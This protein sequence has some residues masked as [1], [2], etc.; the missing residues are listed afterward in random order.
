[1]EGFNRLIEAG[2]VDSDRLA[3]AVG[4]QAFTGSTPEERARWE[5]DVR[6][7]SMFVLTD[8]LVDDVE[9]EWARN[10]QQWFVASAVGVLGAGA[11]CA[12]LIGRARRAA[13]SGNSEAPTDAVNPA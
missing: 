12:L 8:A 7:R 1:M 10:S 4:V 5:S 6:F 3:A 2:A 11:L 9:S 13:G